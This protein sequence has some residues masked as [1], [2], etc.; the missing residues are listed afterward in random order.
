LFNLCQAGQ[1]FV[2]IFE[3][4][5]FKGLKMKLPKNPS[6]VFSLNPFLSLALIAGCL[7]TANAHAHQEVLENFKLKPVLAD[8]QDLKV[9]NIPVLSQDAVSNV[10]YALITPAMQMSLQAHSHLLG[11]CAGFEDL[12]ADVGAPGSR[13]FSKFSAAKMLSSLSEHRKADHFYKVAPFAPVSVIKNAGIEAALNE[14]STANIQAGVVWLSK[15]PTRDNRAPEPN[16]HVVEMEAALKNMLKNSP[17]PSQ[18][19]LIEHQQTHQKSIRVRLL[20]KD[21]PNEIIV[22]GGHLDSINQSW[23]GSKEAPGADDNASGSSDL[24]EALRV[25]MSKPQPQRTIEFFWYAGEESGLLGSAEIARQYKADNMNVIAVMQLD[26]TLFPGAGEFVLGNMTDFTSSWLHDYF[27]AANE[28]YLH[29]RIV[30]DQCGYGC[31]DHASWYR[32]G[33]PALMPFEATMKTMNHNIHSARDVISPTSNF[34]HAKVFAKLAVIFAM[35]LGNSS[36][37]Q[38]Y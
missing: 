28:T 30:D 29:V 10:G 22:L 6:T 18:V 34:E 4:R 35:D 19:D 14:V 12:T 37:H 1:G 9:L 24:V 11:K 8:L 23:G 20:G 26:M 2:S 32:Q 7:F 38:P 17:L 33:Y 3:E 25:V 15:F 13:S 27:K 5:L 16:R 36:L 31:S 21:R